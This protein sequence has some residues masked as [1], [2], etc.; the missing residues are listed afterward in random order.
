MAT[1]VIYK[2]KPLVTTVKRRK[3]LLY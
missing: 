3:R 1:V 2:E